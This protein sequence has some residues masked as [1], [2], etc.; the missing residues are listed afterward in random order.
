VWSALNGNPDIELIERFYA[1]WAKGDWD[2]FAELL[3]PEVEWMTPAESPFPGPHIGPRAVRRVATSFAD[4][5]DEFRP[6]PQSILPAAQS[7]RYLALVAISS[8][9][10]GSGVEMTIEIGHLIDVRDGKLARLK[11]IPNQGEA[12]REAGLGTEQP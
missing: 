5:F 10:K 6:E 12:L 2:R 4:S 7:G 8:R 3:H 9:G 11:V 1:I